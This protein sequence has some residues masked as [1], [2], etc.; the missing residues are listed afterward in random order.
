[1]IAAQVTE[2]NETCCASENDED[3]ARMM[4]IGAVCPCYLG[5][6]F[7]A[8]YCVACEADAGF[9]VPFRRLTEMVFQCQ[10]TGCSAAWSLAADDE[11]DELNEVE[12]QTATRDWS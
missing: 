8:S 1:V 6:I 4:R 2:M 12:A 3:R 9:G 10:V 5:R 11:F 7:L